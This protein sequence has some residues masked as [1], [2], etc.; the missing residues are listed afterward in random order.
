MYYQITVPKT[1][2][3]KHKEKY[4]DQWNRSQSG[5]PWWSNG[6]ESAYAGNVSSVPG[7]GRFHIPWSN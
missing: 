5:R 4:I 7:L 3:G 2:W 6:Y 1:M